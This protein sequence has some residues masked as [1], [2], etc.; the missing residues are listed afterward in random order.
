[1]PSTIASAKRKVTQ[2]TPATPGGWLTVA[3]ILADLGVSRR[4]W[5]EWRNC[6]HRAEEAKSRKPRPC[7]CTPRLFQLPNRQIRIRKTD[8]EAWLFKRVVAEGTAA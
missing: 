7:H 4:T 1:M 3:D 6:E 8:Y 5:Q 2:P